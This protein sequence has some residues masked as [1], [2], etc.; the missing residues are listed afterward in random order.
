MGGRLAT[1]AVLALTA[2][3]ATAAPAAAQLPLDNPWLERRPLNIAHQGGEIENPSNTLY[4]FTRALASGADM[5]ETDV[6]LTADGHVVAIHDETVD[7]TTNGSG[8]VEDLT[9]AQ[10]KALDAAHW[11]VP[12]VGTTHGAAPADYTL[13]GVATGEQPPPPGFVPND[14]T[15]ATLEEILQRWPGVP[16]NVELKPTTKMTGRLEVAVAQLLAEYGRTD[17]VIVVSFL[18]HST[19]LFKLLAPDVHT[20]VGTVQAGLF[21]LSAE[22]PLPGAPNPRYKALQVPIEF[23]GIPVVN[24]D[25]VTDA[26]ANA[27]AVHVWTINDA[28]VMRDLLDIGA[29]GVMTD[30]PALLES[31]LSG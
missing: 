8:S 9:L 5:L 4:A 16:L 2:L 26:H 25:F 15:V 7:R 10:I 18:D 19:E 1:I 23:G 20:A 14:F 28:A 13:R 21:K 6:H 24:E 30:R 29:D 22:G 3:A 31:V 11:F 12:D 17:D 27:F